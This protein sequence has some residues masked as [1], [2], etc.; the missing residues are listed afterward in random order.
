MME[1]CISFKGQIR[2]VASFSTLTVN[3]AFL[4]LFDLQGEK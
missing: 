1:V 3:S 4:K 2:N